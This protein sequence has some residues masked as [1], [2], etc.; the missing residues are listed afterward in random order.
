MLSDGG[1]VKGERKEV[2]IAV[3]LLAVIVITH[4]TNGSQCSWSAFSGIIS[5]NLGELLEGL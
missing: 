5:L 1:G 4:S 2:I 3:L